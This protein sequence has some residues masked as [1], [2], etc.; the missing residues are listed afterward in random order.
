MKTKFYTF[1][2]NNSGGSFYF[3]ND[4]SCFV[5]IEAKSIEEANEKAESIGIYFDGCSTGQDCECCGD[6]WYEADKYSEEDEPLLYGKPI[7]DYEAYFFDK[8]KCYCVV[9]YI[10][11]D[12]KRYYHE[13]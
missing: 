11:G 12:V 6:R 10:N 1:T 5:I 3:S 9:H 7:E 4:L 13:N 8:D 2:Q